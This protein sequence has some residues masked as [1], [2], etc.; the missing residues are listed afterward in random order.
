LV[1]A[2][3]LVV[4]SCTPVSGPTPSPEYKVVSFRLETWGKKEY[5]CYAF[6]IYLR[7]HETLYLSW[8]VIR[9]ISWLF[10]I[11]LNSRY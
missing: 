11:N 5:D 6:G 3:V 1:F 7:N 2:L 9:E 4:G 10:L 8:Q